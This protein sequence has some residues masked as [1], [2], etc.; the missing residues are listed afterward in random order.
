MTK[1]E[2][3]TSKCNKVLRT[4]FTIY[5]LMTNFTHFLYLYFLLLSTYFEHHSAHHQEIELY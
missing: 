1:I 3:I 5:L 2:P 4:K